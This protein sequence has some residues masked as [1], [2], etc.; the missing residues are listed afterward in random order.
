MDDPSLGE[1]RSVMRGYYLANTFMVLWAADYPLEDE[2]LGIAAIF[3]GSY[4]FDRAREGRGEASPYMVLPRV[5][6]RKD[7]ELLVGLVTAIKGI[8]NKVI[9][10]SML[11]GTGLRFST[12]PE[13]NTIK[14]LM[15]N[16]SDPRV[17]EAF[18]VFPTSRS[19]GTVSRGFSAEELMR[20]E[21]FP[22][23]WSALPCGGVYMV[24]WVD[25]EEFVG[26]TIWLLNREAQ[27]AQLAQFD[28]K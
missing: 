9:T 25:G 24:R 26:T 17:V 1:E 22:T 14:E 27:K 21:V 20:G 18:G 8:S 6:P 7:G 4:E 15:G 11:R 5:F 12:E 28:L 2:S 19:I 3:P 13:E 16:F 10:E 23:I